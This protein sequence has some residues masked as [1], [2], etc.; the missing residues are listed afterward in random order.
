[1]RRWY[2]ASVYLVLC[3]L[4][5]SAAGQYGALAQLGEQRGLNTTVLVGA[6]LM[7]LDVA[8]ASIGLAVGL[9]SLTAL[10]WVL[11]GR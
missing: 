10:G 1:M 9:A 11:R 8:H 3:T 4:I 7:R 6:S 5:G 2:A